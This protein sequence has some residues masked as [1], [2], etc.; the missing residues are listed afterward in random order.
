MGSRKLFEK[1]LGIQSCSF[2]QDFMYSFLLGVLTDMGATTST[3]DGNIYAFRRPDYTM[4]VVAHMDTVHQIIDGYTV[5]H[6]KLLDRYF[7]IDSETMRFTGVG[8]DDKVGL[9][10]ALEMMREHDDV[11]VAFFRDEEVGCQGSYD[12]DMTFFE[13]CNIVLQ[14]DRRGASDWVTSIGGITLASKTFVKSINP[15]LKR[16]GYKTAHGML[17]DVMALKELGFKGSCAN[18]S[19]GYYNPH[20]PNEYINYQ[21]VINTLNLFSEVYKITRGNVYPCAA[22]RQTHIDK[23]WREWEELRRGVYSRPGQSF[24]G[25]RS[26]DI[27]DDQS[28]KLY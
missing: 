10:I 5:Q 16:F 19:C 6:D 8:G 28:E 4:A 2:D 9:F 15:I 20:M 26:L 25:D 27:F 14:A 21:E 12:A 24:I 13:Q 11:A 7:A 1:I 17:T 22:G 18:V 3:S 23:R